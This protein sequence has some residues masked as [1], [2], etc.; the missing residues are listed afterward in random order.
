MGEDITRLLRQ[1]SAGRPEALQELVPALY[2]ELRRLARRALRQE[3]GEHTLQPTALVHEAFLRLVPQ[4]KKDW[5]NRQHFLAVCAQVMRQIL[6]DYARTRNAQKRGGGEVRMSLDAVAGIQATTPAATV[7]V[8]LLD[9]ALRQL[10]EID[11]PRARI[12]ELRYFAGM[13][14]QEIGAAFDRPEW[15]VKKDWMLAK[16]WLKK[17][18]ESP[19]GRGSLGT[20]GGRSRPGPR[21][22]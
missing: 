6:V 18:M 4:Q 19:N 5:K 11:A 22:P 7:D 21:S 9:R 14:L 12:V 3:R 13:T 10:S 8:L 16:A 17:Q 15:E 20:S 2:G 1:W